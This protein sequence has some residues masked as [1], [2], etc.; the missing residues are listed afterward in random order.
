MF[1]SLTFLSNGYG[2]DAI[3]ASLA[4]EF[5][6]LAPHLKLQAYPTVDEGKAYEG[7]NIPIL[8]PRQIMPSGGLLLHS[9][10]LFFKDMR[11]GFIPMTLRQLYDLRYLKTDCLVVV[12]DVY[13]LTLSQLVRC[14]KRFFYQSIVSAYHGLDEG[15]H[16]ANRYTMEYI[17]PWEKRLIKNSVS[18]L[19]VRDAFSAE[20][21]SQEGIKGLA[22]GN[23]MVDMLAEGSLDPKFIQ[24]LSRPIIALLPGS[25]SYKYEALKLMFAALEQ[26]PEASGLIAWPS[27]AL[28]QIAGWQAQKLA[29]GHCYQQAH[30]PQRI[31]LLEGQFSAILRSAELVLGTAGTAHEQAAAL[32]LPVLSFPVLPHYRPAFLENQKRLLASAL[33]LTT[34]DPQEIATA[35]R[36][37]WQEPK[38]YREACEMGKR[39]MGPGGGSF[40]IVQH[41]L[42]H[43]FCN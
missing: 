2:E 29:R 41:I 20:Q 1:A 18:Q 28:P 23:P 27:G 6:R 33:S 26:F 11:S 17:S 30:S 37:L 42:S 4:A 36:R 21:L 7:L 8:G 38:L 15:R 14:K 3:A 31:I 43:N 5:Q 40:K 9:P 32:G 13:A 24:G 16:Y 22:L 34:P 12:G 19:Y 39:R 10:Q 35:L 25:R